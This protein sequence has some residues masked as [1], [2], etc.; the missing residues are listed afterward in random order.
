MQEKSRTGNKQC[1]DGCLHVHTPNNTPIH[2]IIA[3][4]TELKTDQ[5]HKRTTGTIIPAAKGE[6]R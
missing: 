6:A 3:Y 4:S 5:T 2:I 1:P